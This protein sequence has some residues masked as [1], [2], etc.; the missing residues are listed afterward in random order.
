MEYIL[1]QIFVVLSYALLGATYLLKNRKLILSFSLMAVVCNGI[2][3]FFLDAWS[4]LAMSGFAILRNVIFM[5]QNKYYKTEKIIWLD[6]LI[7]GFLVV[8]SALFAVFTYDGLLSL[9][10]VVATMT[11]TVSVWQKNINVY[12]ILGVVASVLWVAYGIFIKSLFSIILEMV[13]L[14]V[15]I[16]GI[17][18]DLKNKKTVADNVTSEIGE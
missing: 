4:G 3:F 7:L 9:L 5:I 8:V 18:R 6:W 10:S 17:V 13:M 15:E 2:G 1:S 14:I 11:Y 16:V 12:K